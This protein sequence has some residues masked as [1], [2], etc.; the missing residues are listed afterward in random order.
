MSLSQ[1]GR[2]GTRG[3][4]MQWKEKKKPPHKSSQGLDALNGSASQEEDEKPWIK[5]P[6]CKVCGKACRGFYGRWGDSGTCNLDCEKE[7][8]RRQKGNCVQ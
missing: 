1:S 5:Q 2:P 8:V 7:E 6:V 3:G 4:D